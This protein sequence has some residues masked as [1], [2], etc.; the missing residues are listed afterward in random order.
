[1]WNREDFLL[2]RQLAYRAGVSIATNAVASGDR[3]R[4][5][6]AVDAFFHGLVDGLSEAGVPAKI[7]ADMFGITPR[8][9]RRK[10]AKLDE[11][12]EPGASAW[13]QLYAQ[14]VEEPIQRAQVDKVLP[15]RSPEQVRSIVHEMIERE[16]IADEG[17]V[18]VAR[19]P[20]PEPGPDELDTWLDTRV[21]LLDESPGIG[22]IADEL[23]LDRDTVVRSLERLA[24][25][26]EGAFKVE[27]ATGPT[28]TLGLR[29]FAEAAWRLLERR[30]D[31]TGH[32]SMVDITDR[33]PESVEE[34]KTR[35]S[36]LQSRCEN[37]LDA[38]RSDAPAPEE[39]SEGPRRFLYWAWL[40]GE[41]PNL[42]TRDV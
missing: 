32:V 33:E 24:T 28:K 25:R 19:T 15:A 13:A 3:P 10:I 2:L 12:T 5:S 22:A 14:I 36:E 27:R 23:G 6:W 7:A 39:E 18:L 21:R 31:H 8:S 20:G 41:G 34:L 29:I 4:L 38:F 9:L 35:Y 40:R 1:M 42:E 16:I 26:E 11:V 17:G 37:L 30:A